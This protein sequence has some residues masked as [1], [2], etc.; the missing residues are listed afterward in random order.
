MESLEPRLLLS[1][2]LTAS[3]AT[4]DPATLAAG[5]AAA[6]T[7]QL[8]NAGSEAPATPVRVE[9]YAS[10]DATLDASDVRVASTTVEAGAFVPGTA[11]DRTLSADTGALA[12]AGSY[13]LLG[14]IDPQN[15][16]AE[17]DEG[18]NDFALSTALTVQARLGAQP[19][20]SQVPALTLTDADGTRFTLAI[21]GSGTVEVSRETDGYRLAIRGSDASTTL[22]LAASG[23]D[24]RVRLSG[25]TA[26]AALGSLALG[27][28]SLAGEAQFAG[29][30]KAITL[31]SVLPGA[32]LAATSLGSLNVSGDFLG[33]LTLAGAGPSAY[34]LGPA[35]VGGLLGGHWQ[36]GGRAYS[37][38]AAGST[39]G[40]IANLQGPLVQFVTTGNVS[41]LM[42]VPALQLLQVG[43][44]LEG[45]RLLVGTDLGSDGLPGGSGA[46]ADRYG[47]GTLGRVRVGGDVHDS[48]IAVG[49]DPVDGQ[50][51]N[52]DDTVL[53]GSANRLQELIIGGRLT[54]S[55]AIVAPALP[56]SVRVDGQTLAPASLPQ[57]GTSAL[58]TVAPTLTAALASDTGT[59]PDDG[60]TQD[61]TIAGTASDTSGTVTLTGRLDGNGGF[62]A[63]PGVIGAGGAFTLDAARLATLAGGALA[64]GAHTLELLARDGAG[65]AT[66]VVSV[67]FVL[68]TAAPTLG[69]LDLDPISDTGTPGDH[70]TTAATVTLI[71]QSE[72]GARVEL[73][74]LGLSTLADALGRFTFAGLAL[75]P[76]ANP[77]TLA[78]T[79]RAGNRRMA[80]VT[81]TRTLPDTTV[82]TLAAALTHDTGVSATDS[83]TR[84]ATI[85]GTASDDTALTQLLGALDPAAADAPLTDFSSLL[86]ADGRFTL[87]A[88]VLAGLA[89]GTLTDGAHV[90]RLVALDAAGNRTQTEVA[91]TL[92]TQAPA[93]PALALDPASDS[94]ASEIDAITRDATPTLQLSTAAGTVLRLL[95]DGTDLGPVDAGALTL[96]ALA[97]GSYAFTATATD[98]AGNVSVASSTLQIVIDTSAPGAPVFDLAADSDSDPLGDHTTTADTVTLQGSTTPG[99]RVSLDGSLLSTTADAGGA[100]TLA[101]VAL[102]L[103]DNLLA[104]TATDVAGNQSSASRTITRTA[105]GSI[106]STAPTLTAALSNDTGVSASDGLTRD[107][108]IRGSATDDTAVTQL[109]GALDPAGDSAPLTDL[110]ALLQTDGSFTLDAA[111]LAT[112]AGSPLVDGAHLLRL[113]A[114]DA[115]G[116]RT[117]TEVAFTLDT[118]APGL[119]SIALA[120][121]ADT[122]TAGDN[123]TS[124]ARVL[125]TG[126]AQ[127]GDR[128]EVLGQTITALA[129]AGGA[130]QLA[131]V[132]LNE[133]ENS[134]SLQLSDRAGNTATTAFTLTRSGEAGQDVVLDWISQALEA[135]RRD[136]TDP[137]IA[138]RWLAM[139]S[140]AVYDTLAAIDGTPAYLTRHTVTGPVSTEAAIATAAHRVLVRAYPAQQA[141]FDAALAASLAAVP[142][143]TAKSAGIALGQ[144]V[145]EDVLALRAGD[146][147]DAFVTY[148]GSTAMGAWR[149]T[150]PMYE[151]ADEPQWGE[152]TPFALASADEFRPAAPPALD[153]AEYAASVEEIR[154]L[155]SAT[156]TVRTAEQTRQ[157]QFW[158]DGA[159][160]YTP[161]GHWL[162][163]AAQLAGAQGNSLAANARLFAQLN[164]ALADA[165]IAAWDAKYTYGLW[166]PETAI[167]NADLDGNPATTP[168]DGWTSLLITPSH[169]EYVSG[170]STFSAAAAGILSATF[171]ADT[172]FTTTSYAL[173]GITRSYTSFDEAAAEAGR[174]RVYGGIHYEF[175][176]QAGQ[177]LGHA[178][179]DAV[180]ARFALAEDSQAPGISTDALA[181]VVAGN[182][183]LSGRV[184]DNLSGIA[185]SRYSLDGA[186]AQALVLDAEGRFVITTAFALDGSA[187]GV[188]TL[189][190]TAVDAAG[191]A[192][193]TVTRSFTLDTRAPALTLTS[194]DDGDLLDVASRLSGSADPTGS[195]LT[196]LSYA[197]DGQARRNLVFDATTGAFDQALAIGEL[198]IGNHT[199]VLTARDAAG[200]VTT[201]SRTLT[202]DQ[203]A[204]FT[205]TSV[206][207]T[208]GASDVGVTFRPQVYFSRAVNT[209]T[210]TANSLYATGPDGT[211]LS[212][213]IVPS[214]DGSF[215]WLFFN[216]PMPGGSTIT[217]HVNG[218][219]IRAASDGAFLDADGDGTAKDELTTT[220][221]TVS[222]TPVLGTKL[223]GRVVDPGPDLLPMTFDDIRRGP[224]GVIHT[225]D[226]VFLNPIAHAKVWILGRES[227]VIYTD[228]NGYFELNN[229]PVGDVKLA[230]DGRTATNA[231]SGV[232]FPEMVMDLTLRPGITNTAM[233]SMGSLAEQ[234][235]NADRQELYLPRIATAVLQDVSDTG[236]TVIT[237]EQ[238]AAPDLTEQQRAALTL[239]VPAGSAIGENGEVLNSVQIGIATVPPELVRDMLPPGVLEHTFDITIQAPGVATF[240]E[241][242]Q[243]T[244]PN[245][246]NAA[247]GTKLNILSFDHTTGRLVI[248]GTG[249]VST[250]G[251]KVVSDP[252]SGIR[253]PGW[254]G[255][256]PPSSQVKININPANKHQLHPLSLLSTC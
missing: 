14:R 124:A 229:V 96:A 103:G 116:N 197:F 1:A 3:A 174:S 221:T 240:A 122:G 217:L 95:R 222:T 200:N 20:G 154:A 41:G 136:A 205:V 250:D 196:E 64:D 211:K 46:A 15:A 101:G 151:V 164:V 36:V 218:A 153:S 61:P 131:D 21:S 32:R 194:L 26:D 81:L 51:S 207:P 142:D 83:L 5:Q 166:R 202:L 113:V 149:P 35:Q 146:G 74:D 242:V 111:A 172:A 84:D 168:E 215:A 98:A 178:V 102:V 69:E 169:P 54:G 209:A 59:A 123:I 24:G 67:G 28:A 91:F 234:Q 80:S 186:S 231:P 167:A 141:A 42:A 106:D 45:F 31:A 108:G 17:S 114:L 204:P 252:D 251:L 125:L 9:L 62:S 235:D 246:F 199:L 175:T 75:A 220:F 238:E 180:L 10:T 192:T 57:L 117:Q 40:W 93:A 55:S 214:L 161:P 92:D 70:S 210:L 138:T 193:A 183:T 115:A 137:P 212:T 230:V 121:S 18:N 130:F 236:T 216:N 13:T 249:T 145:A 179:A 233:G 6:V 33:D 224:D 34:T 52:G 254:H 232:F 94:G 58:D 39:A 79:D 19:N 191:N 88:A 155:G 223:V 29:S 68:D 243:I 104:L 66:A 150:G 189:S 23:G 163:I 184:L 139:E 63:L 225:A 208:D 203:L 11:V 7:V 227:E 87:D 97:D 12:A 190:L 86:Q 157:A 105:P 118:A 171:G 4:L 89:G 152:L 134:L 112:L 241:P 48:L 195:P 50:Y 38:T 156:S 170:H 147:S 165:A 109:L 16:I 47:A 77:F 53:G 72:A 76:G 127:A 82:P 65:N 182:P 119:S 85:G 148:P 201:L 129:G 27:T 99:S 128:I 49:L 44:S 73:P 78:A 228:A 239:T 237:L 219:L 162:Q 90:L 255:L 132:A 245:V 244:F 143:G 135:V 22:T 253:A 133:G 37:L 144:A 71:G 188:H 8:L 159:G 107:A 177:Q 226:D 160:T 110:S 185:E 100:F 248:N 140:L 173:P 60:L 206:T 56:A 25:L 181:P 187:D 213:T 2:D 43:G 247:P 120:A 256:T 176:N 30:V 198:G 126:V 158:A